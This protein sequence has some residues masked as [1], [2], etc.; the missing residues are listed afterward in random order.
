M[1]SS[2]D[3]D[4]NATRRTGMPTMRSANRG[5]DGVAH[6]LSTRTA[7]RATS[8]LAL[9]GVASRFTSSTGTRIE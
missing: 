9:P 8:R 1:H 7:R 5:I 6:A 4:A 2:R 3:I